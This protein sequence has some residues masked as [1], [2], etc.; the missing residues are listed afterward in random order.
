MSRKLNTVHTIRVEAPLLRH[1]LSITCQCSENYVQ[2]VTMRLINYARAI[3]KALD[4]EQS[5]ANPAP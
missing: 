4:A 2:E 3:N 5:Q 1:G